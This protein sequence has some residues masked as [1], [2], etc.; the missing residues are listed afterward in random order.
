[1]LDKDEG[2]EVPHASK[3][4]NVSPQY[5]DGS[6]LIGNA[7]SRASGITE[8]V[9]DTFLFYPAG[10]KWGPDGLPFPEIA[11]AQ[12]GGVVVGTKG[13]LPPVADQS[14]LL[15]SLRGRMMVIGEQ[16]DFESILTQVA[17]AFARQ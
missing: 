17:T 4:V 13:T 7:L 10:T 9:W 1:M 16:T 12:Q 3:S 14:R 15:P 5:F 6:M 8:T 11:I 2:A